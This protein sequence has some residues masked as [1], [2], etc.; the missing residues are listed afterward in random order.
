MTAK[1]HKN[2]AASIRARLLNHA[3]RHGDDYGRVLTRYAIERVA[4]PP[5]QDGRR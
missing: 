2:S 4:L 3:K 1:A 5:K